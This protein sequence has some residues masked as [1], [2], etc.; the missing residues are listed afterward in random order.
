MKRKQNIIAFW[1]SLSYMSLSTFF[2]LLLI[3]NQYLI[4]PDWL[5][6]IF[7]PGMAIGSVMAFTHSGL[8]GVIIAQLITFG[9]VYLIARIIIQFIY[10]V[11]SFTERNR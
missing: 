6:Y 3:F 8:I 4:L 2:L 7:F 11:Y 1:I 10:A 9:F 5:F